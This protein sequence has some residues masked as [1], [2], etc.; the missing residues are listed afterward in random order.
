MT[1]NELFAVTG[2]SGNHGLQLLVGAIRLSRDLADY[3]FAG[4]GF[5]ARELAFAKVLRLGAFTAQRRGLEHG[6][7]NNFSG[8]RRS[9]GLIRKDPLPA[10]A[11]DQAMLRKSPP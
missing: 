9:L 3:Q 8:D 5:G 4:E 7:S 11:A 6:R 1:A 10:D 2:F